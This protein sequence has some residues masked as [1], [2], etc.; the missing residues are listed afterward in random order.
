MVD[1]IG[2]KRSFTIG[3]LIMSILPLGYLLF[4]GDLSSFYLPLLVVRVIHG[5]GMAICITAAF[6]Y[7]S[8]IVPENRRNEGIGIFGISGLTGTAIGPI[9]AELIIRK[10]GFG[11][12]FCIAAAMAGLGL[13]AHL[14]LSETY[15]HARREN[16]ESF[17]EVLKKNRILTVAMLSFLFGFGLAGSNNFVSPFANERNLAFIS[18]YYIAYSSAAVLTRLIGGGFADR[19]GESKVIPYALI[20]TGGGLLALIFLGG[21]EVLV[22]SG[23]MTGCGHGFLFPSLNALAMRDE[24]S[25]IRGKITGV[26]TGGIDAGALIGSFSLGYVGELAGFRTLFFAAG[27]PLLLAVVVFR[28]RILPGKGKVKEGSEL[29]RTG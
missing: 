3:S 24:P 11:T 22:L 28:L 26:F 12:C 9:V 20:M 4:E 14:P 15:V 16:S 1:R 10:F 2:R 27:F 8:D 6:T 25:D 21:N 18:L 13:L 19:V 29:L 5:I 7:A 17:F 23:L